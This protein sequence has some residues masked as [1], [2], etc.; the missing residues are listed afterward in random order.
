MVHV[1]CRAVATLGAVIQAISQLICCITRDPLM[2]IAAVEVEM[3]QMRS[4]Y[5]CIV[6]CLYLCIVDICSHYVP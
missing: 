5:L 2:C 3:C 4:L 1:Q 6:Y